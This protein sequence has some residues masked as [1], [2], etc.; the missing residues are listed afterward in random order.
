M[1]DSFDVA[2]RVVVVT[3]GFGQIGA[4]VAGALADAGA[5]VAIFDLAAGSRP[6]VRD[7]TAALA[8]GTVQAFPTDITDRNSLERSLAAV[9]EGW[10]VPHGLL[11]VAAI[12]APPDAPAA[13]V[14]RFEDV[15]VES[16]RRVLEVNV[17]GA[18]LTCQ[19]V[20]GAMAG[21]G[22]GSVVNV[23]S[24]YGLVSPQQEIYEFRRKRGEAFVKPVA[25][26][27][28]KSALLNLT[29][30]LATYWASR[31]RVN[32][33]TF[34]GRV[35]RPGHGLSRGVHRT[36]ARGADAGGGGDGR[37]VPLPAL[38]RLVVRDGRQPR[39]G[40]RLDG[41]MI[42]AEIPNLVAGSAR[43]AAAGGWLDKLR[44]ADGALLCRVARSGSED[45]H[46]AVAAARAVQDAWASRTVVARGDVLRD[47]A[48]LLRDRRE[49]AS[50]IVAEETG[51]SLALARGETDAAV[52]MGL[53]VAGE[54][55]RYYGRTTTASM[56]HRTVL[57]TRQPLGVAGLIISFNTPLPNVAWKVFPALLCGNAAVL[58]PSEETPASA[59]FFGSLAKEAGVPDG[60]LNV[61]QG[62]GAE[63]GAALVAHPEVD[64]VSF[65][66]SAATGRLVNECAAGRLAKVC[67]ELGGKN[68][69]VVCDDAELDR[70]VHWTVQSAFSNA[71]QR[72][73]AAS[74]V[75]VMDAV[76]D[77]FR[78]RLL[79]AMRALTVGSRD[80]DALGPVISERSL[81]RLL[82]AIEAA[83]AA[84]ATVLAGG[85]RREGE[86]WHLL[87]TLLENVPAD[88]AVAREE[89]FGPVAVLQHAGSFGD[90][91]AAVND[92]RYGLTAAVHT[93]SVH[94]AMRFAEQVRTG[95]VVVNAGTHGSE[96]HM[97]FGGLR[98]SGTGWREAGVEALDVYSDWKA[99]NIVIDP[100]RA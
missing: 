47:L 7:L 58:K 39:R 75:I 80:E 11:N 24:I 69:L 33:V 62:Q 37:P 29:R 84:G 74:R 31:V 34:A 45:V 4:E 5:R 36:D 56:P 82:E 59:W 28:S 93:A 87:P 10:G 52:E 88:A 65:T 19:V 91:V 92:S 8:N 25:Y 94:R 97:G 16:L 99:V 81:D 14:G 67:L 6:G 72:C 21:A 17:V 51:K 90:A 12:D 86:G 35:E 83:T 32:T 76:Y 3:G 22:R 70:A 40:R 77:A 98:N 15:P 50:A 27:V 63:A 60:V 30:Y 38:G 95:V 48:L 73:A 49:E 55:R 42:P 53:F 41:A 13:E 85:R 1:T 26:S 71:G 54:G 64:L 20:G 46:A 96:P 2:G 66:G 68:A 89:L 23:S 9:I 100:E 57:T 43:Q 18:V 44:P 61:V 79:T 78:E